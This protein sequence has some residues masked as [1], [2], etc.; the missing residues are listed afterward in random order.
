MGSD[1]TALLPR[2]STQIDHTNGGKM[3]V[4]EFTASQCAVLEKEQRV[5]LGIRRFGNTTVRAMVR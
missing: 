4:V 1:E 5:R 3:A 2:H